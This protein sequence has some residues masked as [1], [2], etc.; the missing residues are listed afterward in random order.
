MSDLDAARIFV[1]SRLRRCLSA[2]GRLGCG[3]R[4][5]HAV[6]AQGE[7]L[8]DWMPDGLVP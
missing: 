6:L 3:Y 7:E 5:T 2:P 8:T 1:R 4:L